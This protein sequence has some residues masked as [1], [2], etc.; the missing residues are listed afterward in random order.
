[1]GIA[2]AFGLVACQGDGFDPLDPD[3]IGDL[4]NDQGDAQGDA[5]SG[6]FAI[7]L[8]P[9]DCDC[10]KL[11]P[12]DFPDLGAGLGIDPDDVIDPCGQLAIFYGADTPAGSQVDVVQ[13]DGLLVWESWLPP[14][15]GPVDSDGTFSVGGSED[16]SETFV[17]A[18]LVSRVDAEYSNPDAFLG[19]M[20]QR[21]IAKLLDRSVDCRSTHQVEGTRLDEGAP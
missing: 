15:S 6:R 21:I 1:M 16:F 14:L 8:S 10:P 19:V 12:E 3:H 7:A 2:L 17:E 18:R 11:Y 4:G 13:V 20:Q 9:L 5:F